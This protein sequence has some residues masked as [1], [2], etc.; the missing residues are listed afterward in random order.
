[1]LAEAGLTVIGSV[2][3]ERLTIE[4]QLDVPISELNATRERGLVGFL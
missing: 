1:M 3:G 2:G 4:D